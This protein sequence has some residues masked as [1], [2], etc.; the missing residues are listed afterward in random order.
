M[1]AH[2]AAGAAAVCIRSSPTTWSCSARFAAPIWGWSAPGDKVTIEVDGKPAGEAATAGNDG[3]WTTK[4]G[5]FAAGGPHTILVQCGDQKQT[6]KNV[7]F[8]DVWLCSGPVEHE[9]AGPAGEQRRGR[10]QSGELSRNPLVHRQLL[11]VAGAA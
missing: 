2:A 10:S 7:L 6:L 1:V 8:G 11:F 5:P 4:I 9:L 3:R